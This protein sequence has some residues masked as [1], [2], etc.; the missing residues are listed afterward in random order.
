[1]PR[2]TRAHTDTCV[3]VSMPF[4]RVCVYACVHVYID[5]N[6]RAYTYVHAYMHMCMHS[7][8]LSLSL[9]LSPSPSLSL[10]FKLPGQFYDLTFL[11]GGFVSFRF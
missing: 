11:P 7:L 10:T 5:A 9:S 2:H 1:M 3:Y 8:S 4:V 6:T